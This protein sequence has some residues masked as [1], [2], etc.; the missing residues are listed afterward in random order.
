[1]MKKLVNNT[2]GFITYGSFVK[3]YNQHMFR[4]AQSIITDDAIA[5]TAK[6]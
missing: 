4:V 6:V 2:E 1:M 5:L 3:R